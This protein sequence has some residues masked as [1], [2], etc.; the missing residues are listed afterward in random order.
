MDGIFFEF[1]LC[2]LIYVGGKRERLAHIAHY[3]IFNKV[4][5][6]DKSIDLLV[7]IKIAEDTFNYKIDDIN[8]AAKNYMFISGLLNR[9]TEIN[10]KEPYCRVGKEILVETIKGKFEF[11]LFSLLAAISAVLGKTAQYKRIT[12]DRLRYAMIGYKAKGIY[13][14]DKKGNLAPSLDRVIGRLV[15]ILEDKKLITKFTYRN[16]QTFY[17]TRIK[18][19]KKLAELIEVMKLKKQASKLKIEDAELSQE[20]KKKLNEQKINHYKIVKLKDS[21]AAN[22]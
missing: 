15:D 19:K 6:M 22:R 11:Q 8:I 7:R 9:N 5:R 18:T 20:I 2:C 21:K 17:S 13:Y 12:K 3:Y 4:Y 1:P 10:G 16:R 14:C